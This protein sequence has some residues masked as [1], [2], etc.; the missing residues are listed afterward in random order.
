MVIALSI[1]FRS[2]AEPTPQCIAA[3]NATFNSAAS[4][5]CATAYFSLVFGSATDEQ[6]MMVCNISQPCY[7]MIE[8]VIITCG[9]TVSYIS[10]YIHGSILPLYAM[11]LARPLVMPR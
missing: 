5:T 6:T 4:A 8:N 11:V 2:S 3:Y 10:S 7:S 1:T 9:N